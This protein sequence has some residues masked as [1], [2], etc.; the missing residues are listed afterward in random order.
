MSLYQV[1]LRKEGPLHLKHPMWNFYGSVYVDSPLVCHVR[2]ISCFL[3]FNMIHESGRLKGR[4]LSLLRHSWTRQKI[5][6]KLEN[7]LCP[8]WWILFL[9]TMLGTC[10]MLGNQKFSHFLPQLLISM[11]SSSHGVDYATFHVFWFFRWLFLYF[12]R[13]KKMCFPCKWQFTWLQL[14]MAY[15]RYF[16]LEK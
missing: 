6:H 8:R 5:N 7:N 15:M 12:V 13:E 10:L 11:H 3:I 2:H 16:E 4:L 14:M 1:A 9:V